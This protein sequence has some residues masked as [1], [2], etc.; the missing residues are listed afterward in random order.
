MLPLF[1]AALFPG[2]YWDR[3]P[4]TAPAVRESGVQRLYVPPESEEAWRKAGFTA[5]GFDA[6]RQGYAKAEV[7]LTQYRPN[8]ASATNSPWIDAN[9]WRFVRDPAKKWYYDVPQRS[10]ELA[11]AEAYAYG[12]D[13]VIHS[14]PAALPLFGRM[15]AFL[16][17]IDRPRMPSLVNIGIVDD[18]SEA[19]GEVMNMAARRNLLFRVTLAPDPKYDLV[20]KLKSPE[21]AADPSEYAMELRRKLGDDKRLVRIYGSDVVLARLCGEGS[22]ARLHLLNYGGRRLH[23]FRVRVKGGYSKGVLRAYGAEQK[24][25]DYKVS[26]GGVEFTVP[27]MDAYAVVDLEK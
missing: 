25:A 13:A 9:G 16:R 15:L 18:G 27:A 8:E 14:E 2:L 21:E 19:I 6:A 1:F 4:D 24:L 23:S 7:P 5:V 10:V 12:V 3:P 17:S 22:Q 26:E 11:A 20:V